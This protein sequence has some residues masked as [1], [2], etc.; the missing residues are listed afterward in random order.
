MKRKVL[1]INLWNTLKYFGSFVPHENLG[2]AYI[3]KYLKNKKCDCELYDPTYDNFNLIENDLSLMKDEYLL[4]GIS[5]H[6]HNYELLTKIIPLLRKKFPSAHITLGG[7]FATFHDEKLLSDKNSPDS[8]IRGEGEESFYMLYKSLREG[9]SEW[10]N[11]QA[12]S[13]NEDG[14]IKR[15]PVGCRLEFGE[16]GFPDRI[17]V[18]KYKLKKI[19]M[20]ATR[21]CSR[22]CSF[23]SAVRFTNMLDGPKI[24]LRSAEDIAE[25]IIDLYE[26]YYPFRKIEFVDDNF[27]ANEECKQRARKFAQILI[28][29]KVKIPFRV[30]FCVDDVDY[31]LLDLLKKAGLVEVLIGVESFSDN[32]LKLYNKTITTKQIL[33]S[34]E[35]LNKLNIHTRLAWIMFNPYITLDD[36]RKNLKFL[37]EVNLFWYFVDLIGSLRLQK[38]TSILEKVKKDNLAIESFPYVGYHFKNKNVVYYRKKLIT[39][40]F[41]KILLTAQSLTYNLWKHTEV[42][43]YKEYIKLRTLFVDYMLELLECIDSNEEYSSEYFNDIE[44][45]FIESVLPYLNSLSKYRYSMTNKK[46]YSQEE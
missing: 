18:E 46:L 32:V 35:I 24:K 31:E 5:L 9:N 34:I 19:H 27:L 37:R 41:K 6:E 3:L 26:K 4:I 36:I 15:N 10:K 13:I 14:V 40:R 29:K 16:F 43:A 8:I 25:E 44:D 38:G 28:D 45:R 23:C 20:N 12:L 42:D 1:L 30:D 2:L 22:F 17:F 33:K 21:G 39:S 7:L 11:S